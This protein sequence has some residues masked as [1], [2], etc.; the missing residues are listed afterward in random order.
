[1]GKVYLVGAGPGDPELITVKGMRLLQ[2]ADVIAYDRLAPQS[3]LDECRPD[4]EKIY[5]GKVPKKTMGHQQTEINQLLIS[6]A[7]QGKMVVRLKG[8]D[9]FVFGRGGEEALDCVAAGVEFEIVPGV[10][11][12]IAVPAYAGVPVTHR[13]VNNMFAVFSGHN[14]P[15]NT[16]EAVDYVG[17]ASIGTNGTLV[18]LMGIMF[19]DGIMRE[20]IKAGLPPDTPAITIQ[21]GTTDSQRV[22]ESTAGELAQAVAEAEIKAPATTVIGAV[23]ELRNQGLQWYQ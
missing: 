22:V 17:L 18:I 14:D 21:Q 2:S 8:G 5:V 11:S 6:H 13:N 4:A 10:T 1:M 19:L 9:P 20:L 3:L 7:Q 12:A 16:K 15:D 23:T